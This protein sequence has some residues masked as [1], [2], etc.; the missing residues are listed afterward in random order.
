[1]APAGWT[2]GHSMRSHRHTGQRADRS[3]ET[4]AFGAGRFGDASEASVSPIGPR[5]GQRPALA[6]SLIELVRYLDVV[7]VLIAT[8]LALALG[9]PAVGL[10]IGAAAWLAQRL[11]AQLDRRLIEG[12]TALQA[13]FGV[14]LVESFGRIWLLAGA[15]V[16]A[17][18]AGG[19][20]DGLAASLMIF[21]AYSIAFAG[22]LVEGRP[23][24]PRP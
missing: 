23:G 19:R 13:R 16:I 14:T 5:F 10:V 7:V 18:V 17:A 2:G 22:R 20:S 9:A 1:M 24:G 11:L 3:R 4:R 15:I 21:G 6:R 8:P 12:S